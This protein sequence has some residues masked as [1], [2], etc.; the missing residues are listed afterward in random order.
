MSLKRPNPKLEQ[1]IRKAVKGVVCPVH[2]KEATVKMES[3]TEPVTV[4]ACCL[5]FKND[6]TLLAERI[7]K[8]F[9]FR[10]AKT[11]ERIERER[12]RGLGS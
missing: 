3:E 2:K 4:D 10:D 5:F 12:R 6:I 8:D 9:I 1:E 11:R 7:R